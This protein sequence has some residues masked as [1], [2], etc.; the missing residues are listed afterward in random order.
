MNVVA[1]LMLKELP[2]TERIKAERIWLELESEHGSGGLTTS[3]LWTSTWLDVFGDQVPHLFLVAERDGVPCAITVITRGVNQ[4]R[5]P[6]P[7]RTI[8]L[9]TAGEMPGTSI[10]AEYVRLLVREEDREEV[11]AAILRH[12]I[13]SGRQWEEFV[14]DGMV[15]LD[16]QPFL[17]CPGYWFVRY[18]ICRT[19]NFDLVRKAGGD[20][21]ATLGKNT[22]Y[23][24]RRSMRRFGDLTLERATTMYEAQVMFAEMVQLHQR[25]WTALGE[26]GAFANE[27]FTRFHRSIIAGLFERKALLMMRVTSSEQTIGSIYGFIEH[28]RVLMYQSGFADFE[29]DKLKPGLVSHA[30]V[31]QQC[32]E[33]GIDEY[34]FLYGDTRYKQDLSNSSQHLVYA[35]LSKRTVKQAILRRARVRHYGENMHSPESVGVS[36]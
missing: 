24:I 34:D 14:F 20:L 2:S 22:R 11:S 23:S 31:M 21:I 32:L 7:V 15:P 6:L 3:W 18:E 10:C 27:R 9:G 30:M 1:D 36:M 19:S 17:K 4:K 25:H 29:D 28:N 26:P 12:V 8:H 16:A 33:D 13:A 5:G 35:V